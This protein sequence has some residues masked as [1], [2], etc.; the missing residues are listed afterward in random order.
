MVS[1]RISDSDVLVEESWLHMPFHAVHIVLTFLF[2]RNKFTL[3][4]NS[5]LKLFP[6]QPT[7]KCTREE[8]FRRQ[9][10]TKKQPERFLSKFNKSLTSQRVSVLSLSEKHPPNVPIGVPHRLAFEILIRFP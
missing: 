10:Y 9:L 6:S 8:V 3:V 5:E 7:S 1:V 2:S 4:L